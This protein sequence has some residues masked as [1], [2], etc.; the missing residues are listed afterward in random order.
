MTHIPLSKGKT[1]IVDDADAP[2]VSPYK[3][4]ALNV[5][6]KWYAYSHQA[7]EA[8][9]HRYMHRLLTD[10]PK[11]LEVDHINGDGLDNRQDNLRL[12][13]HRDNQ[14]NIRRSEPSRAG[15]RGVTLTP[16]GRY[17]ARCKY[18]GRLLY[19]GTFSTAEEA[20]RVRDKEVIKLHGEFAYLNFPRE[21]YEP[22]G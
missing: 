18:L 15:Y 21:D 1:T 7:L 14:R 13:T 10:A 19:F 11:G 3:W 5:K 12:C 16:H 8:T 2:R 22:T 4:S 6:G 9:G 17:V 20:A